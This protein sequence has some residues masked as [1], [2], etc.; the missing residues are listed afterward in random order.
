MLKYLLEKALSLMNF[1]SMI[2][3]LLKLKLAETTNQRKK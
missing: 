2:E 3:R 1:D